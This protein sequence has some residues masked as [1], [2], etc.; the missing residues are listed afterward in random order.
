MNVEKPLPMLGKKKKA[1]FPEALEL[2]TGRKKSRKKYY[3]RVE[4]QAT[5]GII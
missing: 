2:E 1:W 5:K 4:Q 3:P